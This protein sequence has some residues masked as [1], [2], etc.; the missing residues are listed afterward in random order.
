MYNGKIPV[1][2][3]ILTVVELDLVVPKSKSSSELLK[4]Q[5]KL[6][7]PWP[8]NENSP[9]HETHGSLLA[10]CVE[11]ELLQITITYNCNICC[12]RQQSWL[13]QLHYTYKIKLCKG[14]R[15]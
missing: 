14:Y 13:A 7:Q 12:L 10:P 15:W 6:A 9:M 5:S 3:R 4:M 8:L 2:F 11:L 1:F